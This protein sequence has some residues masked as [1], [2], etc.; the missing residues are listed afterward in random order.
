M[1]PSRFDLLDDALD[2]RCGRAES[3]S[4]LFVR[5]WRDRQRDVASRGW[6]LILPKPLETRAKDFVF[7]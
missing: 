7:L 3:E 5:S 1:F 4:N 6:V 2:G